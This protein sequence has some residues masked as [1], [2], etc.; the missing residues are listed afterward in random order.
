MNSRGHLLHHRL[1]ADLAPAVTLARAEADHASERGIGAGEE[2]IEAVDGVI[3]EIIV[4]LAHVDVDLPGELRAE[5]RPVLLHHEAKVI[6]LPVI[7][8][9][10]VDLPRYRVPERDWA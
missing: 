9:R 5:R 1:F 3:E 2:R 4:G 8:H 7:D 10:S 6:S